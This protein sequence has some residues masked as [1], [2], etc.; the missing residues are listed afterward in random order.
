[1]KNAI[2]SGLI[3]GLLSGVYLLIM[4]EIGIAPKGEDVAP[5]EYFSIL[6]PLIGLYLGVRSYRDKDKGGQISF[7]DALIQCFKIMIIGGVIAIFLAITYIN[8]VHE[9]N[10]FRDLSGRMFG[11][12]L[13]GVLFSLGISL[14]L[15]TKTTK[16][17]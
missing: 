14:L 1:M 13:V 15:M 9:G 2:L 4:H 11:A 8:W 17:D 6:I 12:L 7:L 5:A 16:L 3:I 10:N